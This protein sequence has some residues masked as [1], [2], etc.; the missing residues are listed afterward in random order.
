MF[1]LL[2]GEPSMPLAGN[3]CLALFSGL[4]IMEISFF[5]IGYLFASFQVLLSFHSAL[6]FDHRVF[7]ISI[8]YLLCFLSSTSLLRIMHSL[9][10]WVLLL[11]Y[12][13]Y[14]LFSFSVR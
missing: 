7:A 14:L 12:S 1:R 5:F 13:Q 10:S 6:N 8:K 11:W 3:R 4:T 2:S 9:V